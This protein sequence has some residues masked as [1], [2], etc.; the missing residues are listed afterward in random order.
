MGERDVLHK[1][2]STQHIVL[3]LE[4]DWATATVNMYGKFRE[5]WT[6]GFWDMRADR[7]TD[8]H[9]HRN[10]LHPLPGAK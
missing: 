5:V 1:T 2:G 9:A 4:E 8:R 3:S 10:T 6:C 7:Q